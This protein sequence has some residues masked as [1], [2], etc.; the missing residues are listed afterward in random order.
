[1]GG[2]LANMRPDRPQLPTS[3]F[4]ESSITK[5][6]SCSAPFKRHTKPASSARTPAVRGTTMMFTSTEEWAHTSVVKR[7]L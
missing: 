2:T 4:E 6:Q 5:Q 3:T 7:H 1:M